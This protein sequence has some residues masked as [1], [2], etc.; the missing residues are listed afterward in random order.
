[1]QQPPE[2]V[3]ASVIARRLCQPIHRVNRILSTRTDIKPAAIVGRTRVFRESAVARV[4]Y[5]IN[6][7]DSRR[8]K[9]SAC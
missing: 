6:V 9:Q 8:G 3:T 5:E 7:I 1:M 4:R 2:L